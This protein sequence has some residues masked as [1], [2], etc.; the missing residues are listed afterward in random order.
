MKKVRPYHGK[1]YGFTLIELLVVIAMIAILASLLLPVLG[2]AK[3]KVKGI[4]CL[5]NLRQLSLGWQLYADASGGIM[6][7]GRMAKLKERSGNP[8]NWYEV[9]N[10]LKYRPRWIATMG[11]Y[12]GVHAFT[13]PSLSDDRQDYASKVYVCPSVP[14][15]TD[16]RGGA[17]G[18]NHQFLGNA[19]RSNDQFHHFPVKLSTIRMPSATVMAADSMG[20]AAG[21]PDVERLPYNNNGK[22]YVELG[23][24]GWTLDPPRLV[25]RSDRGTGDAGSPRTAVD[26][27]HLGNAVAIFTDGHGETRSP[28]QFGYV[29]SS[30]GMFMDAS[31]QSVRPSNEWFSGT[32]TDTLPPDKP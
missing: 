1:Q 16:E 31:V 22:A 13:Q 17:Y 20:T 25:S 10:G 27:R 24:H 14:K 7:P 6:V 26:P 15:W 23:N 21:Y 9:G 8:A 4:T 18:Y 32:G 28:E 3:A 5:S 29:R 12:V 11:N 2:M 30:D 19:R